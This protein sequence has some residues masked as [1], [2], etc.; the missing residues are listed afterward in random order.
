MAQNNNNNMFK[1]LPSTGSEDIEEWLDAFLRYGD[2]ANWDDHRRFNAM[3][4]LMKDSAAH[5]LQRQDGLHDLQTFWD[6]YPHVAIQATN[7]CL[8]L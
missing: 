5:W 1:P 2:Y 8:F 4:A 6:H 7:M 3:R